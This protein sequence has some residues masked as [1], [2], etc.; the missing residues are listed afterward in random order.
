MYSATDAFTFT[1][2][3]FA[4]TDGAQTAS[5]VV[6][7]GE[8]SAVPED[9]GIVYTIPVPAVV[10]GKKNIVVTLDGL[11]TVASG[12]H[13]LEGAFTLFVGEASKFHAD[14]GFITGDGERK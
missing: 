11:K 10:K 12:G 4:Y 14:N 7:V 8:V 5:I 6:P 9:G 2:F 13:P 3:K 1:G